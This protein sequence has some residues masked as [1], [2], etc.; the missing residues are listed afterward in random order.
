[1]NKQ[2][3]GCQEARSV[4]WYDMMIWHDGWYGRWMMLSL[5]LQY[6][7]RVIMKEI[8]QKVDHCTHDEKVWSKW[9]RGI[10]LLQLYWL[11]PVIF[12]CNLKSSDS[13]L[14]CTASFSTVFLFLHLV[15]MVIIIFRTS[16]SFT[17]L[18]PW[19]NDPSLIK[20]IALLK[21]R[22]WQKTLP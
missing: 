17:N 20:N 2:E 4:I 19:W 14:C 7:L 8:W 6:G 15:Q 9:F 22:K 11:I 3:G 12:D 5:A 10:Q 13:N 1:M 21:V 16:S 18:K